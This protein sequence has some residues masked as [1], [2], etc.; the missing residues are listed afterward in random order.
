M[1]DTT[2]LRHLPDC[3]CEWRKVKRDNAEMAQAPALPDNLIAKAT[4]AIHALEY[5]TRWAAEKIAEAA[6]TAAGVPELL[7]ECVAA[8]ELLSAICVRQGQG[9]FEQGFGADSRFEWVARM[10]IKLDSTLGELRRE[11]AELATAERERDDAR[12]TL[13]SLADVTE[14]LLHSYNELHDSDVL[15]DAF[16]DP[17]EAAIA[18]ARRV[19][20]KGE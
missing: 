11:S 18:T 8:R 20:G 19:L 7:V 9:D 3:P 5:S 4:E 16:G 15:H 10:R 14:R 1:T 17:A 12:A 2:E 6:L 13:T